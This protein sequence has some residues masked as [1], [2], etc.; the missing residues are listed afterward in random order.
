MR[1][2]NRTYQ[3]STESYQL[4]QELAIARS[5]EK[6]YLETI[7]R[8]ERQNGSDYYPGISTYVN[9]RDSSSEV[10]GEIE[11]LRA[12]LGEREE[13]W[14]QRLA[15]TIEKERKLHLV[16]LQKLI[17]IRQGPISFGSEERIEP[18]GSRN[19]IVP[20]LDRIVTE[21]Q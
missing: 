5:R 2:R 16:E 10:V 17:T 19:E 8:L 15:E 18:T 11:R 7:E 13:K 20:I 21:I 3:S 9:N 12:T 1:Q 14:N 4:E 6:G